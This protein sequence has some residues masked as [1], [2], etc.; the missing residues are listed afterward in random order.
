[1]RS[2]LLL[3]LFLLVGCAGLSKTPTSE[4]KFRHNQIIQ[5]LNTERRGFEFKA[6]PPWMGGVGS[7]R[8]GRIKEKEEIERELLRRYHSGD[9][10]AH[11]PIFSP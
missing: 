2:V 5:Y 7:E 9:A 3:S 4:L 1:M 11:L 8:E 10:A 6:G